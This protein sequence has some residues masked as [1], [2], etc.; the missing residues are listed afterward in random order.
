MV[1]LDQARELGEKYDKLMKEIDPDGDCY[2]QI[3]QTQDSIK[4]ESLTTD[5]LDGTNMTLTLSKIDPEKF[6]FLEA[7][8]GKAG[9]TGSM[10]L[11]PVTLVELEEIFEYFYE[12][13]KEDLAGSGSRTT[14]YGVKLF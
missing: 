10:K 1:T 9:Y 14:R 11:D 8:C 2:V 13:W 7:D 12:G 4:F 3:T 5:A 6:E